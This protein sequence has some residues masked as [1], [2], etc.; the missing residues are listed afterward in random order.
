MSKSSGPTTRELLLMAVIFVSV[1]A[2]QFGWM[3][4]E[5]SM[6]AIAILSVGLTLV[7]VW[8]WPRSQGGG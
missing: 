1:L 6:R 5:L 8:N 3:T 7:V 4:G 2:V